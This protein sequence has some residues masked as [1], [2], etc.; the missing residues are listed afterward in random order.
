M[1][2]VLFCG[3]Y[4]MRIREYSESIPKPMV[5]VGDRPVLWH[6]MKYYAHFG[7]TNFILCLGYLGPAIKRYF[8][9]YQETL[10]N[11][12]VMRDGG[13]DLTLLG[14]D[15]KDWTITFVDTGL[16]TNIGG[17]LRKV[18]KYLEG[19][20]MFLAN[21]SDG[22]TDFNLPQLIDQ[23][24]QRDAVGGFLAVRPPYS[25]HVTEA[26]P[27]GT[28]NAVRDLARTDLRING[29]YF[30]FRPEIFDYMR[31]GEELVQEPFQRLIDEQRL[32]CAPYDGFW[33]SMD[34]FKEKQRLDQMYASGD[35]PWQLWADPLQ[36]REGVPLS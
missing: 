9:E 24:E 7:H 10:S 4:G 30:V 12:F 15:I 36:E 3:G 8:L 5:P 18:R 32:I 14:R 11:D 16:E 26:S 35:R 17:R 27:D 29:G 28:V 23:V 34:T 20:D 31:D 13:A 33:M 22:L 19:E 21:Y 25:F 6:I 2:V 1:K